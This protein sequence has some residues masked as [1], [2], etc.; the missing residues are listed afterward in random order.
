ML[1]RMSS[2]LFVQTNGEPAT[3]VDLDGESGR[4]LDVEAD[5]VPS[6]PELGIDSVRPV[7]SAYQDRSSQCRNRHMHMCRGRASRLLVPAD[8]AGAELVGPVVYVD[9]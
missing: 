1:A 5:S 4:R 3:L 8:D 6:T 2:A 9:A 7:A